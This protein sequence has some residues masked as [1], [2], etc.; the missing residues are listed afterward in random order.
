ML[1]CKSSVH[2]QKRYSTHHQYS[3][4]LAQKII[5]V[6]ARCGMWSV[7]VCVGGGAG[8]GVC[9]AGGVECAL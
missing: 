2:V 1:G 7:C 3:R 4:Y 9:G 6:W 5:Q 8:M